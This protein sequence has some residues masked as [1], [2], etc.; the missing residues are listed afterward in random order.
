MGSQT[1]KRSPHEDKREIRVMLPQIKESK[2]HQKLEEVEK[3][4]SV[5]SSKRAL[6]SHPAP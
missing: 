6:P 1:Q 4:F 5:E 2:G 3:D